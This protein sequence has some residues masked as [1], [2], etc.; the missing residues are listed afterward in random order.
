[1]ANSNSNKRPGRATKDKA[2][3][4]IHGWC[5]AEQDYNSL[6]S[7]ADVPWG[8]Y[9]YKPNASGTSNNSSEEKNQHC[10][11]IQLASIP[12]FD[13]DT[14]D[15]GSFI[16]FN[17]E[18]A[19][20]EVKSFLLFED[21][22]NYL[23]HVRQLVPTFPHLKRA[24]DIW[25]YFSQTNL[26]TIVQEALTVQ[27]RESDNTMT[28]S[29]FAWLTLRARL[30]FQS[31]RFW[32]R[33]CLDNWRKHC[34]SEEKVTHIVWKKIGLKIMTKISMNQEINKTKCRFWDI[35]SRQFYAIYGIEFCQ[36][37]MKKSQSLYC[38][39]NIEISYTYETSSLC[40]SW[41]V[42]HKNKKGIISAK[43]PP[44]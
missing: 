31:E 38:M 26:P 16:K 33:L 37:R 25:E 22:T 40:V 29:R 6:Y 44:E 32:A 1:M 8:A 15:Y 5:D 17:N 24:V 42:V 20:L 39:H 28:V 27:E 36:R 19:I 30:M 34:S 3:Q 4:K 23:D 12:I 10:G 7:H 14:G 13:D 35:N 9:A 11:Q 2:K 21:D 43:T 18:D 41:C